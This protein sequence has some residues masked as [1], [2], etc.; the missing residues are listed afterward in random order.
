MYT[1]EGIKK[2]SEKIRKEA[3][4]IYEEKVEKKK[5]RKRKML[6]ALKVGKNIVSNTVEGAKTAVNK[7]KELYFSPEGE[8]IKT[9]LKDNVNKAVAYV[10]SEQAT[11]DK[12]TILNTIQKVIDFP[13]TEKGQKIA[14]IWQNYINFSN[15]RTRIVV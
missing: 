10:K 6:E 1:Q 14:K 7:A 4:E 12:E 9:V 11:K 5:A 3:E 8:K 15:N 2:Y 13:N